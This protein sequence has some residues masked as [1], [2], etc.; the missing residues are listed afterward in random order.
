MSNNDFKASAALPPLAN[1]LLIGAEA[2]AQFLYDDPTHIRD[3][4]RNPLGLPFFKH[5]A[6]IAATK[7]G[8]LAEIRGRESA[9]RDA[10]AKEAAV[11]KQTAVPGTERSRSAQQRPKQR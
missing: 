4:Y 5:G 6:K 3:V 7:S 9:A 11:K 2:I 10:V 1:D 8:L